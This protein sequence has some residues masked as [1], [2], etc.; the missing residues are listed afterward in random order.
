MGFKK[1]FRAQPVKLGPYWRA[2]ER[3]KRR[4]QRISFVARTS[5]LALGIFSVGMLATNWSAVR[6]RL[7]TF[8]PS[9]SWARG[10]GAAPILRG[11][12]GY[13]AQLDA[14]GD[15]IACEAIPQRE[16]LTDS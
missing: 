1:E 4:R 7:P 9:C 11:S 10:A 8:Y 15:G 5:L 6:E 12:P 2:E 16:R 14:D 3:A 13:R